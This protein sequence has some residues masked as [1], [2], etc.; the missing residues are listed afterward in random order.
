MLPE[1]ATPA[2]KEPICA[3]FE[4]QGAGAALLV[5]IMEIALADLAFVPHMQV[6]YEDLVQQPE[7]V[8]QTLLGYL[9]LPSHPN[10]TAFCRKVQDATASSHHAERQ[11][12]W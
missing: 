4:A 3:W 10:V 9:R 6:R 2:A 12:V 5:E 11:S 1:Q 8:A 7:D